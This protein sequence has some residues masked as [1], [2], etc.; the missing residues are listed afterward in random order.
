MRQIRAQPG[1]Q[2]AFLA[3]PYDIAIYGGAAGGGKSFAL[4][5]DP[6]RHVHKS[7]FGG[8]YFR[9]TFPQVTAEGALWDT[10]MQIYPHA[11]GVPKVSALEWTWPE[12]GVSLTMRHM[13][14]DHTVLDWQGAALPF[15]G[16][17]ELTH[18]GRSQFMYMLSRNRLSVDCGVKPYIRATCNPDANSW[19]AE[20]LS[21]WIGADGLPIPE[22]AGRPLYL[23]VRGGE[24]VW[25]ESPGEFE[26]GETPKS[27][28]FIPARLKDNQKLCNIDPGYA[29][30]LNALSLVDRARLR[31][32]N[33]KVRGE[34]GS[35]ARREWF[36]GHW[37][38]DVP[39]D[40]ERWVRYWDRAATKPNQTNTDPD[41]TVGVLMGLRPNRRVVIADVAHVRDTPHRTRSFMLST[42]ELDT[43]KVE[44]AF[45]QDPAAAGKAEVA[46]LQLAFSSFAVRAVLA[47]GHKADRAKP[48]SA[49]V[50]AGNVDIVRGS[51]NEWYIR[52]LEMFIDNREVTEPAGYHDDAVD[53]SSGAYTVLRSPQPGVR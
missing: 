29:S 8:V 47:T 44:V 1:P 27:V 33:W 28:T 49:G 15:I 19:V 42:A 16:Y 10:S 20:F 26:P 46:D 43:S 13:Q 37:L 51:W 21:W 48:F 32:G 41:Y 7:G 53:A 17:D 3:C 14:Y 30:N 25:R 22:R 5:M 50:E 12:S 18:F 40:V 39:T 52:Q 34:P 6:L 31:D 9:R 23:V 36:D 11:G 4:L 38:D 24:A 45:E 35:Y 2:E